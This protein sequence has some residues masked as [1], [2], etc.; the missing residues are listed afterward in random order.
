MTTQKNKGSSKHKTNSGPI[1]SPNSGGYNPGPVTGDNGFPNDELWQVQSQGYDLAIE[2]FA[3]GPYGAAHNAERL[4]K[5]SEWKDGQAY[6]GRFRDTNMIR[7]DRRTALEQPEFDADR[8]SIE[9][10]N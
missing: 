9:G 7:S 2:E 4:G 10:Q 5:T 3:E 8:G 1:D 6:L